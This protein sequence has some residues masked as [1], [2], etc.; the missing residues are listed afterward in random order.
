MRSQGPGNGSDLLGLEN[1][2][3]NDNSISIFD[4]QENPSVCTNSE[5]SCEGSEVNPTASGDD[6][7]YSIQLT[8]FY[9]NGKIGQLKDRYL[10]DTDLA[11]VFCRKRPLKSKEMRN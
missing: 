9:V 3:T 11:C 4:S 7:V 6:A 8:C 2:L 5:P 10:K 1:S